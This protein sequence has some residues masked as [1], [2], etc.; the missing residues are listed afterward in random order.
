[1]NQ[2]IHILLVV[3]ALGCYHGNSEEKVTVSLLEGTWQCKFLSEGMSEVPSPEI[4]A[5]SICFSDDTFMYIQNGTPVMKGVFTKNDQTSP[6]QIDFLYEEVGQKIQ[7][8]ACQ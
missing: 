3:T 4:A 2:I 8:P 7:I 6:K 5:M 1:M